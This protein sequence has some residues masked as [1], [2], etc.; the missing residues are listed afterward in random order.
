MQHTPTRVQ[1]RRAR[2]LLTAR[3]TSEPPI[4][5]MAHLKKELSR[6][7]TSSILL[8]DPQVK[9]QSFNTLAIVSALLGTTA[10]TSFTTP[11]LRAEGFVDGPEPA[12]AIGVLHTFFAANAVTFAL[13]LIMLI[14]VVVSSIPRPAFAETLTEAG[15]AWLTY[16]A[17]T[18]LL[19]GQVSSGMLAF[20]T[21]TYVTYAAKEFWQVLGWWMVLL[22]GILAAALCVACFTR[23]KQLWPGSDGVRGGFRTMFSGGAEQTI[24]ELR[25]ERDDWG[26]EVVECLRRME[27]KMGSTGGATRL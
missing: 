7:V 18:V 6:R 16:V 13:A 3:Q 2:T 1:P 8:S 26:Q 12:N 11:P 14:V 25:S 27:Q 17:L 15:R 4:R 21:G 5:S 24:A 19:V 10:F 23:L 20:V 9:S 22:F